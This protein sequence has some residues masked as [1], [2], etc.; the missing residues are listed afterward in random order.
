MPLIQVSPFFYNTF[1]ELWHIV[2]NIFCL[3]FVFIVAIF[4]T[5]LLLLYQ[6]KTSLA[7]V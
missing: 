1:V 4:T 3:L 6:C 5:S 7:T 2:K